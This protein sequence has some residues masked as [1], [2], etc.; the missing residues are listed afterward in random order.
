[1][2]SIQHHLGTWLMA[3]DN[4]AEIAS[5][6]KTC[7]EAIKAA[8]DKHYRDS[9]SSELPMPLLNRH[10]KRLGELQTEVEANLSEG[11]KAAARCNKPNLEFN[12]K[13]LAGDLR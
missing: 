10:L 13:T 7:I 4:L 2:P 5:E 6:Y 11:N 1:M 12:P 3:K 8:L 9:P